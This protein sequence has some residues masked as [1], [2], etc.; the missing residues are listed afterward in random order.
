MLLKCFRLKRIYLKLLIFLLILGTL[1]LLYLNRTLNQIVSSKEDLILDSENPLERHLRE[2]ESKIIP[3]LGDKGEPAFLDGDDAI[4]GEAALKK[5]ALNTILSDRMP[6]DR[7]LRDP[8]NAK[9]KDLKYSPT[10]N[11]SIIVIFYNEIFSVI[12]RTVWSVLLQTPSHL[13]HEI[14]LVDDCSTD[15]NLKDLL[16]YYLK[17]R[18]RNYNIK[19]VRLKHRMG[20]IRARLQGARV[21]QGDVLVF[22]DAHC[23]ATRDWIEPLLSRVEEDYTAVLVPIIDVIEASNM[24]YSTNGDSSFQVGGFSWSGHFTWIDIQNENDKG[25][26]TPVKSPTMAGGLFAID[27]KFFWDVGSYDEQM[28]GWG[29]ENLEMSFRIWQCGGR[30]ETVPCSRVGHI[31][32][33]FHP[34][35]F[36]DNKDTH[37][38]NTARL[39]HVWMDEYKRL[40]F[41]YQPALENN[42]IIGDLTHRKQ[43]RQKL[44]CKSFKW[45]LENVYPEKF[46][47][48]ENVFGYGQVKTDFEMCLDDLQL[49]EEKVG[50]LGLYQCHQF[51]AVSQYFSLSKN[52]EL[53]KE[54]ICAEVFNEREVQLTECH[55]HKR[56]QYWV[57]YK[58]GTI[59]NPATKKCLSSDGVDNGKGVI[60]EQCKGGVFQKWTFT[61]LNKTAIVI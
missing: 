45:Y 5:F 40:F 21:A 7:E 36:P 14:I 44:R 16:D 27:R 54:D 28:D 18:L 56:E 12:L 26:V 48:D 33:D 32:R 58:N 23:E 38:I 11:A 30:L 22:L 53:R 2:W 24:G 35:S 31:F 37:G 19:L 8:R 20:L 61:N 52:G 3:G 39:A 10:I 47:P 60:V 42:P 51:F 1:Y 17:T 25:K 49:P 41:M 59:Y 57:L 29:G 9:C 4:E 34:Y 6:L 43:L 46:I 15:E 13:L 50:P 55:G